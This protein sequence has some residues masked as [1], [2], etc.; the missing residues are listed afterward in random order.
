MIRKINGKNV[1][2]VVEM[3]GRPIECS[4]K[5]KEIQE[6]LNN[7][8]SNND[9]ENDPNDVGLFA[10]QN[11]SPWWNVESGAFVLNLGG[12][13]SVAYVNNFQ[14]C[15]AFFSMLIIFSFLV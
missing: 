15:D 3:I 9:D 14:H 1:F 10:L 4:I 2:K 6:R 5:F 11:R 13:V 8:D 12:R 7:P